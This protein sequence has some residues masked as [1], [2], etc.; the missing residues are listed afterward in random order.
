[1]LE[2]AI[3]FAREKHANQTRK[4]PGGV[5]EPYANHVIRVAALVAEYGGS[6]AAEIAAVLHDTVED[7]ET[8]LAE[9]VERF[10]PEVARL[11]DGLTDKYTPETSPGLNRKA[12][13]ASEVAR[14]AEESDEVHLVKLADLLDNLRDTD[15]AAGFGEVFATEA[16]A[17]LA[18]LRGPEELRARVEAERKAL[19]LKH[20]AAEAAKKAEKAARKAAQG[21]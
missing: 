5:N 2:Q 17:L 20:E 21:K 19:L 18:V 11:V 13:K 4:L 10:G 7:T 15:P 3:H 9:I 8:T 14:V 6:R 1:M 12:R 16:G